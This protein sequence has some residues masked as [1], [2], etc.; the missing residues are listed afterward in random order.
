MSTL[1]RANDTIGLRFKTN[2]FARFL[3]ALIIFNLS[4]LSAENSQN[5]NLTSSPP[6]TSEWQATS[7]HI[8]SEI[9]VESAQRNGEEFQLIYL[10]DGQVIEIPV[11]L[12]TPE[13][14]KSG[15]SKTQISEARE[16]AREILELT[17]RGVL[18]E[19]FS[20][21]I[22]LD[23]TNE[24]I[25]LKP[26]NTNSEKKP[27][28]IFK[29]I[30]QYNH[31][32]YSPA[33][34]NLAGTA[35]LKRIA[36]MIWQF[37]FVETI[38]AGANYYKQLKSVAPRFTEFGIAVDIKIEP[39]VFIAKFNPTQKVKILS[40]SYAIFFEIAYS[41][42]EHRLMVR[43]RYRR[44][45][46]AGGLGLPALKGEL[47]IFQSDGTKT[48]YKG[49]SW[50][51]V[52]PPIVSFVLD[53]SNHYF[54]QGITIGINSGDVIPGSTLTNTFTQFVQGESHFHV[55]EVYQKATE[56]VARTTQRVRPRAAHMQCSQLFN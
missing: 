47:K 6:E 9:K 33:P 54:A 45:K 23:N 51:P 50:Y 53:S 42:T 14:V 24:A 28:N 34:V 19:D 29:R 31:E 27:V 8:D 20:S 4:T 26:L 25:A 11:N 2:L 5:T 46:G 15:L 44:E 52:S 12:N 3:F 49:K 22:A 16:E 38:H 43:T 37:V 48:P 21:A 35:K 18:S 17:L 1:L 39:Q 32:L 41:R 56:I 30:F 13:I 7:A 55:E 36:Q 10:P 40:R